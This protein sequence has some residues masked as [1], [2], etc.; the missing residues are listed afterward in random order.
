MGD[1]EVQGS[2]KLAADTTADK[3]KS[4]GSFVSTRLLEFNF[5]LL[6]ASLFVFALGLDYALF[7]GD[8]IVKLRMDKTRFGGRLKFLTII[9][10]VNNKQTISIYIVTKKNNSTNLK[11]TAMMLKCN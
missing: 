2:K 10:L 8:M 11:C 1:E 3:S 4:K 9:N 6:V 5:Y 7:N